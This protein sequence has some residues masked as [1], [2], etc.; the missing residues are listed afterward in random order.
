MISKYIPFLLGVIIGLFAFSGCQHAPKHLTPDHGQYFHA[1]F[2]RQ[3][4]NPD[5]PADPSPAITLPGDLGHEIYKERYVKS[6]T[7]EKDENSDTVS[8]ELGGL[9]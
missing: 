5:G 8:R 6:M 1:A 7:E 4:L 2:N 9:D 3:V